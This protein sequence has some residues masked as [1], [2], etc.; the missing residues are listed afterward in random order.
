MK[1]DIEKVLKKVL[2]KYTIQE[3]REIVL[4][5]VHS[6]EIANDMPLTEWKK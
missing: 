6:Y 4:S 2:K 3:L 5:L 1:E